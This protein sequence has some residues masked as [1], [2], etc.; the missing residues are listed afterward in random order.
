MKKQCWQ[1]LETATR[2]QQSIAGNPSYCCW[3]T[4]EKETEQN[5]NRKTDQQSKKRFTS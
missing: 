5:D 2:Y 3:P 1:D 4:Y